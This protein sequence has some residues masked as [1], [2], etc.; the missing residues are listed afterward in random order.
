MKALIT[1][2]SGQDGSFLAE[3]LLSLGYEVFGIV[4]RNSTPA[5]QTGRINHVLSEVNLFY[6]D[7]TDTKSLESALRESQ[8]DEIYNLAAQSHVRV[9]FEIPHY[10]AQVNGIGVLNILEAAKTHCPNARVYQ[11]S[12][13]EMFGLSIDSD[14]MQRE[15]TPMNPTSPYGC[16]KL[17]GYSIARHYRRAYGMHISNGILFNHTSERRGANFVESKI[18]RTAVEIRKGVVGKIVLG[19][20]HPQRD[21]G[22]SRD[23]VRAM[24]LM[25]QQRVPDDYVVSTGITRSVESLCQH[26]FHYLGMDYRD[27]L[28]CDEAHVRPEELPYLCG[29]S[30]KAREILGW[31]PEHTLEDVLERMIDEWELIL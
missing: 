26:V 23:Y 24:H 1:G 14:G 25:L 18:V 27:Y 21:W 5:H 10:T 22:S 2:I 28:I 17:F 13:S 9:S 6:G 12:S 3:Y 15:T 19:N 16:A 29:D 7:M 4:R 31:S 11:A 30:S 8:P 20:I